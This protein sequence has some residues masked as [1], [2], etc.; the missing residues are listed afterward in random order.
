MKTILEFFQNINMDIVKWVGILGG[1]L[2]SIALFWKQVCVPLLE[3]IKESQ[4]RIESQK[5]TEELQ[6]QLALQVSKIYAEVTTN[7]GG[8][9]KDAVGRIEKRQIINEQKVKITS[10]KLELA[11]SAFNIDGDCIESSIYLNRLLNRS[12]S[13]LLGNQWLNWICASDRERVK[14]DWRDSV[15]AKVGFNSIYCVMRPDNTTI[16]I[17]AGIDPLFDDHN[18]ILGFFGTIEQVTE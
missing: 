11:Y 18:N 13:E 15:E 8:S 1:A 7:G 6:Q 9:L 5:R 16:K 12:E 2:M 14:K 4:Q 3:Y 17:E 10:N